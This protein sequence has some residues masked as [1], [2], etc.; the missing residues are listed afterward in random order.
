MNLVRISGYLETDVEV[1][2]LRNGLSAA[3][4]TMRFSRSCAPVTLLAVEQRL[5][6]LTDFQK[7][8]WLK[9]DG[10]IAIHPDSKH[11]AVLI[12]ICHRW[13]APGFCRGGS[14]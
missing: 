3:T 12:D 14:K 7:G 6:Q 10:E 4:A 9:V 8:D 11:F 1:R 13:T 5:R 2:K